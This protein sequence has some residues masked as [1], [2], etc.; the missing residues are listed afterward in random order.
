MQAFLRARRQFICPALAG[1]TLL[2]FLLP[3]VEVRPQPGT[4]VPD[5]AWLPT[6]KQTGLDIVLTEGA[7]GLET[8]AQ[9]LLVILVAGSVLPSGGGRSLLVNLCAVG[10]LGLL[11]VQLAGKLPAQNDV[12]ESNWR[13]AEGQRE[14]GDYPAEAS[15]L[16]GVF[17]AVLGTVATCAAAFVEAATAERQEE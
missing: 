5:N 3:W 4:V 15:L 6:G 1:L 8:A 9:L 10:A 16:P 2:L 14:K 12:A 11:F 17:L 7:G 13:L